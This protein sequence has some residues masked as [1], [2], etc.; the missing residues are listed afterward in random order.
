[1]KRTHNPIGMAGPFGPYS[2]V[3]E[4]PPGGRLVY[5]AGAIAVDADGRVVGNGDMGAQTRQVMEN[6]R[7]ALEAAGA[8]FDDVVKITTYVTDVARYDELAPVRAEYLI[9]PFPASTMIEVQGL[10]FPELLVEIEAIAIV[11]DDPT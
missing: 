5:C 8:G 10:M 2:L 11:Y 9:E 3:A 1:M 4:A 6:L 7:L